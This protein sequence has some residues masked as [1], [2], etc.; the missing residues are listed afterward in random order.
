MAAKSFNQDW[1]FR[2]KDKIS[3]IISDDIINLLINVST[4]YFKKG[5]YD[6]LHG[7]LGP[8]VCFLNQ[9]NSIKERQ[10][11]KNILNLLGEIIEIKHRAFPFKNEFKFTGSDLGLSHGISSIVS[12]LVRAIECNMSN[13][14][15]EKLLNETLNWIISKRHES[16]LSLYPNFITDQKPYNSRLAWCYGDLGIAS[17]FW[18]AGKILKNQEWKKEAIAIML[19]S[20]KR[21]DL[22]ENS[23]LDAC[24]CHGTSGIAHIFNRF[25]KETGRKE[26]NEARWYWLHKT[27]EMATCNN[28]FADYKMWKG[29]KGW[30]NEYG[31]LEGISGIGLVLLGFLTHDIKNLNWDECLLLS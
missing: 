29:E 27:L 2:R 4:L 17:V 5:D 25:Y 31:L 13:E 21:R 26:F 1:S 18:Q 8:A 19:H 16:G 12:I 10:G 3:D 24:F 20:S 14:R 15:C 11:L 7:G 28:D 9:A 6:Y 22:K 30:K 23:V